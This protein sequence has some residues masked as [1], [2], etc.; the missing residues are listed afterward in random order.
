MQNNM[1]KKMNEIEQTQKKT[2]YLLSNQVFAI[3]TG[4]EVRF[5]KYIILLIRSWLDNSWTVSVKLIT[6][7]T[8]FL[9]SETPLLTAK[10]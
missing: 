8:H 2:R 5:V 4:S 9:C 3:L 1:S 7:T 6:A 10:T